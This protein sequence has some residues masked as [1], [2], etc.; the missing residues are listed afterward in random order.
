MLP[1]VKAPTTLD[2]MMFEQEFDGP[3]WLCATAV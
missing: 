3:P 2:G 1:P